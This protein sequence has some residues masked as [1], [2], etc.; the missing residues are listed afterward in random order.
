MR[1]SLHGVESALRGIPANQIGQTAFDL[2]NASYQVL[3][4]GVY[5]LSEELEKNIDAATGI[6]EIILGFKMIGGGGGFTI[7]TV[8]VGAIVGVPTAILGGV[9]VS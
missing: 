8:G 9:F 1:A 6:A 4:A 5:G 3:T 7:G 2:N